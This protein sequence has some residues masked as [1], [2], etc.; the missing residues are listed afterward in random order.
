MDFTVEF[1]DGRGRTQTLDV[2][3]DG[4]QHFVGNY[5]GTGA[6]EQ[7]AV[8]REKDELVMA[9]GRRLLRLH[10]KDKRRW[11]ANFQWAKLNMNTPF[12]AYSLSYRL[13]NRFP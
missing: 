8:D 4:E 2:E 9:Q 3:V 1:E 11:A 13:P 5:H 6:E 10:F 12:V 7:R